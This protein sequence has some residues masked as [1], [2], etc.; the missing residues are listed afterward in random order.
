MK[1]FLIAFVLFAFA[2]TVTDSPPTVAKTDSTAVVP[3]PAFKTR[4]D[5]SEVPVGKQTKPMQN[6][7]T[8]I[9]RPN[10]VSGEPAE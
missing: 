9:S 2:S 7:A 8:S 3:N 5:F 10:E 6:Q 4:Q 1:Y